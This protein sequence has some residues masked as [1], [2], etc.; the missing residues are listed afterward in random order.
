MTK[1]WADYL[2]SAASGELQTLQAGWS[3]DNGDPDNFLNLLLACASIQG[4]SN[5]A[6]WCH[7]E[8]SHL[9]GRARVTSN[10][11]RRTEFYEKA[12]LIFK[13]QAP[14]VPLAHVTIYK[15]LSKKVHG[16]KISPFGSDHFHEVEVIEDEK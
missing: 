10:I 4:G 13:D 7:P 2:K 6:R 11:R 9:V 1:D 5:Y 12:Q 15:I 16:Y 3:G 8:Y 14:W